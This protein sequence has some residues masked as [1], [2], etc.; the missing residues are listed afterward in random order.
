MGAPLALLKAFSVPKQP[1]VANEDRWHIHETAGT[2]IYA[3]S[4]GASV[5]FDSAPW[6]EILCSKFAYDPKVTD[7]WLASASGEYENLY[8]REVMPW[9]MQASF[10]QGAFA[11]LLGLIVDPIHAEAF[12][13][14]VGDSILVRLSGSSFV[15]SYPYTCVDQFDAAP[16]LLSTKAS[17]NRFYVERVKSFYHRSS[18][19]DVDAP[20]FL[21]MTDALGRW[22]LEFGKDDPIFITEMLCS[23]HAKFEHFVLSERAAGRL[24]KDDTT[25]LIVASDVT[26]SAIY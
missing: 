3:L 8:N 1:D 19:N 4:D 22:Y 21:M 18:L 6:A 16:Q 10:D 23:S 24:R 25:L 15:D 7:T 12:V 20:G 14:A 13:V 2:S 26:L 11:S 17:H 5:S 9:M